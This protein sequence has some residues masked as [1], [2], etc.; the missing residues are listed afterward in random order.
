MRVFVTGATG[1][2][3]RHLVP[4]LVTAGHDVTATT[5]SP[6]KVEGLRKAGA[7][8]VVLDGLDREAVIAAVLDAAPDV[9]VH[10]MTAL[11]G[12][13]RHVRNP[14]KFFAATNE[15]RTRGTDNLLDAAER[16]G[17]RRVVAQSYAGLGP[18]RYPGPPKTEEDTDDWRPIPGAL[19]GRAAMK[20]VEETVPARV[21][22]GIVLRYGG[23]YGPGASDVLLEAVRKRQVP[24]V[25]GGTG[26]GSFIEITDA[27]SAT[28]AAIE[29]APPG[30]Y[31]IV[32]D[33]P[34]PVREW[35]P[36]L[37]ELAGAKPPLRV[38]TWLA[39]PLAGE[40]MVAQMT[41]SRGYS[42]AKAKKILGWE[43]RY[44]SW[45]E[46]FRAWVAG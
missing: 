5:R 11:T 42:N 37:A 43:P 10:Q 32:D 18:D 23:F 9:I 2:L 28:V 19:R 4:G 36:Y 46:G 16:A 40:F 12:S 13:M 35:L 6:G 24:L 20:H 1:A 21:S 29:S 34:A 3:G 25:G 30:L 45:R 26:V 14:D 22:E 44:A 41:T 39:R 17:T 15:L 33:D 7:E 38:P 27:A 8:P 31:N